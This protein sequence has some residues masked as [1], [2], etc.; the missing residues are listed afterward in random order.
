MMALA[1]LA[2]LAIVA[3]RALAGTTI[4]DGE[5]RGV[6]VVPAAGKVEIVI[7]LQGAAQVSDFTLTNPA[8]LVIDL[9]G[10]RLSAPATLYDGRNRGGVRNVRYGQFKPDVVRVVID[11]DALKDYQVERVGGQVRVRIGT[12]RTA[13]AA[14][15]SSSVSTV[16]AVAP[17]RVAET[18]PAAEEP[19]PM[20][21]GPESAARVTT[22]TLGRSLSIDEY[23][24]THSR[25]AAQSQAPRI[26]VQ[27][28]NASI[29]DVVAGFAAFSGRT[30][31]LAKGITG[32]VTAEIKN[33]PWDLALN[34]VLESPGLA[35]QTL[36]GGILNVVSK[37]ELAR[38]DSTV[39][40]TTRLVRINYAKATS[41]V[42]SVQSILTKRGQAVAD[43]TS[44]SL[45]ITEVSSRIEDVVEF[46]KGLDLRTPQVSI[47]AKIIFVDRTDVEEL[48]VKYDLGSNVQFFNRL[49]QRPDPRSA[50]PVDTDLDGVPDALVPTDNFDANENIVAL[51]GNSLSALGNASQEVINPALD[52]IFS[53][54]IGNFDLTAFVQA[55]QR[56][57]LA[58]V[59]AE[60]TITTLDN[61]QA[62]ILVGDRV[63]IRVIDVSAVNT[64]TTGVPRATVQF[65]QTGIN[66]RVTP[67]VTANRQI[68]MEVHAERSNVQP[69][70]VDI[71][72]TFQTQQ[73]D[74]QILVSDGETAV[75]GGLTV[76]EVTVT[77]SGIPFLVDLPI[78]GKLFGFTSQREQR[79]DLLILITPHII[80]DLAAPAGQ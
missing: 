73:A 7:D 36:P 77:K 23:L 39:P 66:L 35:V 48:G 42:P 75:I 67:H 4:R 62:E 10:A 40:I 58:D 3:P 1:H 43:S 2:L 46:V 38:A 60:P 74:N 5:V 8:R 65:Q 79:R 16:A 51:G 57:E 37:V 53:T 76:S 30:I 22:P 11:L 45:V 52:L 6:S 80:D 21:R 32:N 68:L 54:A 25:E 78:L 63:P 61:R 50:E 64:G 55:L 29:E 59:Q 49:I 20:T 47:Q 71:G 26:T 34:A 17:R 13:F 31:I 41:L 15:S 28:D 24:A 56:V 72:F 12:E 19:M 69:A 44:N 14:W 18:A 9:Q 70:A 27:W 33:Q